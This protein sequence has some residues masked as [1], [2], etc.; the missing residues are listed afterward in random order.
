MASGRDEIEEETK[1][2]QVKLGLDILKDIM[3]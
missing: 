3:I 2:G 1:P